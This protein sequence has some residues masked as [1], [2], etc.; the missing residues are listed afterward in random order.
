VTR[1]RPELRVVRPEETPGEMPG[2]AAA[3]AARGDESSSAGGDPQIALLRQGFR[4]YWRYAAR[5]AIRILGRDDDEV[6]DILQEVFLEALSGLRRL[7]DPGA[8]KAWI[9]TVTVRKVS[10]RLRWRRLMRRFVSLDDVPVGALG[11]SRLGTETSALIASVYARLD[12]LPVSHR[13]AWTLHFLEQETYDDIA[14]ICGC[15]ARTVK[16]RVAE[17]QAL[18]GSGRLG[19]GPGA[20]HG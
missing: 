17:A 8:L 13:V 15:S 6:D 5:V 7:Q 10:R 4:D 18:V 16:R 9:A 20:A 14:R 19:A 12:R 11:P 2:L 3:A 1:R